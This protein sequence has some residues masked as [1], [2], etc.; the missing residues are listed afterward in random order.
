MDMIR[1]KFYELYS[2]AISKVGE[3]SAI[4]IST[5]QLHQT[6][7]SQFKNACLGKSVVV[8]GAGPTLS[9][10]KPIEGAVHIACNRAFLYDKVMFD[11]IFAQDWEGINMVQQE[12]LDY[13]PESCVKL[14]GNQ[15]NGMDRK[16]I[17]ES[18]AISC[19]ALRFNT[20]I[21]IYGDGFKSKFV[22]DIDSRALGNM[23]NVG[24]SVMQF[25]LYMNP[26]KL[27]IVGCD[28]SGGGHIGDKDENLH[29]AKEKKKM[30]IFWK[31]EHDRLIEK[32][33][34]FKSFAHYYYPDTEIISVNPIGLR[35]LFNDW[36]QN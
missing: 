4:N 20:D 1:R 2:W 23:P 30:E 35:G 24:I 29:T 32:W 5:L 27:Y 21:Y 26:A 7:F 33:Q 36:D 15:I 8:C 25:A 6:T 34:E 13:H 28:M 10:Y 16:Q 31:I 17:P 19:N 18:Y 3:M 11:F 12:L 9:H 22:A 14:F